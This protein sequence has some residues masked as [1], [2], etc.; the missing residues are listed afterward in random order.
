M[1]LKEGTQEGDTI[2]WG[3]SNEVGTSQEWTQVQQMNTGATQQ[4]ETDN[5]RRQGDDSRGLDCLFTSFGDTRVLLLELLSFLNVSE[6]LQ[7]CLFS[8]G[9]LIG[10]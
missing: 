5:H 3:K 7:T 4:W 6:V 2:P 10:S 9:L 1:F 8:A